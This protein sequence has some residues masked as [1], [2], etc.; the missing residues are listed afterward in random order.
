[1][2][3]IYGIGQ[4]DFSLQEDLNDIDRRLRINAEGIAT[5]VTNISI[6]STS[7]TAINT[8]L[9]T[10]NLTTNYLIKYD[11][12]KYVDSIVSGDG[13]TITVG[14]DLKANACNLGDGGTTNYAEVKSDG[15]INLHGTARAYRTT[16]IN[17]DHTTVSAHG[18]P[19][20]VFRGIHA[21]FSLPIYSAD[22]EEL[23]SC[24]SAP[25]SWDATADII[26]YIGCYLDTANTGKKFKLQLSW[27]DADLGN[28]EVLSAGSTDIEVETNT[29]TALQYKGFKIPFTM[30]TVAAGT[31]NGYKLG[32]R[33]RRIA[34][35]ADEIAGEVVICGIAMKYLVNKLGTAL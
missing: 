33:L 7:I 30:A 29:G 15:E 3:R 4:Q 27:G 9:N 35:S 6:N 22:N 26:M 13:S 23:F 11:G 1:M 21:G 25:L 19:T 31:S 14:G 20:S 18:K 28:N 17:F 2:S 34:A 12:S 24:K 32:F 5:N 16:T 10:A 8:V